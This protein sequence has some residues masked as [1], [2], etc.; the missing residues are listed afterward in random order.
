M[1]TA[2]PVLVELDAEISR[3]QDEIAKVREMRAWWKSRRDGSAPRVVP[4]GREASDRGPTAKDWI[5]QVL[6]DG[7]RLKPAEIARSAIDQGWATSSKSPNIIIRNQ[8][9]E[10]ESEVDRSDDG[11]YYLRRHLFPVDEVA[12]S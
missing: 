9:R 6:G 10:M 7:S 4:V 11:C 12:G 3:L 8:L 5:R 2:D 1:A